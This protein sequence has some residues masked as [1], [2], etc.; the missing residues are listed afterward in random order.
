MIF[1]DFPNKYGF[2]LDLKHPFVSKMYKRFKESKGIP[3]WCPLSDA[4]RMEFE[5][6]VITWIKE[7]R[8]H[9]QQAKREKGRD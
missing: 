9:E 7:R 5:E 6:K 4:E 8:S 3:R 1:L 2:L